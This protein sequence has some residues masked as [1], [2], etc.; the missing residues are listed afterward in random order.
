MLPHKKRRSIL[1]EKAPIFSRHVLSQTDHATTLSMVAWFEYLTA[2]Q[3][4]TQNAT[5]TPDSVLPVSQYFNQKRNSM[6]IHR[7]AHI[8]YS[9]TAVVLALFFLCDQIF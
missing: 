8:K 7:T 1:R 4:Q 3:Y 5:S 9:L 6:N 2:N